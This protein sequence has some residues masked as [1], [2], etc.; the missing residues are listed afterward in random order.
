MK[1]LLACVVLLA[2]CNSEP[3]AVA[4]VVEHQNGFIVFNPA[5]TQSPSTVTD[6]RRYRWDHAQQRFVRDDPYTALP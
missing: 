4:P 1:R 3:E 5:I 6:P 2:G